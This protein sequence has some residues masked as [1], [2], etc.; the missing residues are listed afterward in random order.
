VNLQANNFSNNQTKSKLYKLIKDLE[1]ILKTNEKLNSIDRICIEI[2][3]ILV[4]KNTNDHQNLFKAQDAYG[5][6][7]KLIELVIQSSTNELANSL[8]TS[9]NL[10]N[11]ITIASRN[12]LDAC[13]DLV[14]SNKLY[15][16]IEILNLH[17]N[18]MLYDVTSIENNLKNNHRYSSEWLICTIV[19]QLVESIFTTLN[20]E[21][22][23]NESNNN[24]LNQRAYDLISLMTSFGLID[25]I[26][27]FFS[28]IRGPL[29]DEP[30]LADILQKYL[31]F[32]ISI[33]KFLSEK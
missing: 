25:T 22:I 11:L 8:K 33:T 17:S 31:H 24:S 7:I 4:Q 15:S 3:R 9:S 6:C 10:V 20:T 12:D 32:L 18:V 19:I 29:D 14:L 27:V 28:K 23:R 2:N 16:L 21:N 1:K 5:T 13:S 26:S 30:Q